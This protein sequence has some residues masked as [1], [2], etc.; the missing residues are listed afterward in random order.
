MTIHNQ[1]SSGRASNNSE[2]QKTTLYTF[3]TLRNQPG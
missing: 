3:L 1:S 2:E